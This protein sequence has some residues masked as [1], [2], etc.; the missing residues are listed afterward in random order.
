MFCVAFEWTRHEGGWGRFLFI[1]Y[2]R[3]PSCGNTGPRYLLPHSI[4]NG[5]LSPLGSTLDVVSIDVPPEHHRRSCPQIQ[6]HALPTSLCSVSYPQNDDRGDLNPSGTSSP[7]KQGAEDAPTM[8]NSDQITK[9]KFVNHK[10]SAYMLTHHPLPR[11]CPK[12]LV[13]LTRV[14]TKAKVLPWLIPSLTPHVH[15]SPTTS[16]FEQYSI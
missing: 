3:F 16:H 4:W 13:W 11:I 8:D 15:C 7:G 9:H 12:R 6:P 1:R 14:I 5:M 10:V 2:D